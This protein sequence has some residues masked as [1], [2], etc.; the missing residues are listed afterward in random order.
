MNSKILL[1][2]D[3]RDISQ[4]TKMY[5]TAEGYEVEAIEDGSIAIDKIQEYKPDLVLLDLMLP[6]KS[7]AEICNEARQFYTGMIMV[8]T[9]AEDEM[10]EVSLFKFGADDYVTKPVRGHILVARIEALMRRYQ[11]QQKLEQVSHVSDAHGIVINSQ[12]Q[13]AYYNQKP[14]SLTNSEFEILQLLIENAGET[15]SREH[16]CRLARGIEY[17]V[18]NRSIDMRVSGLRKKL[19]QAEVFT[20][21]IKT[22]RNQGYKLVSSAACQ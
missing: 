1:I 13:T 3:D 11:R 12:N 15:V 10:S 6:G 21:T 7:G 9:A 5:L 20:A 22:I 2:E 4:L 19:I 16:C 18:N 17:N 14:I 8:L